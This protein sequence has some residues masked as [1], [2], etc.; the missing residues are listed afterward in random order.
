MVLAEGS[1]V[2]SRFENEEEDLFEPN[3][4]GE[5]TMWSM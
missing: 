3:V 1:W 2:A 4:K 5:F